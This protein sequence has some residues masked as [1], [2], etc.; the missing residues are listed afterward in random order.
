MLC[1]YKLPVLTQSNCSPSGY[2]GTKWKHWFLASPA[3][4]YKVISDFK[5]RKPAIATPLLVRQQLLSEMKSSNGTQGLTCRRTGFYGSSPSPCTTFSFYQ[6]IHQSANTSDNHPW[7]RNRVTQWR[8]RYGQASI[9]IK[10]IFKKKSRKERRSYGGPG[11]T[12]LGVDLNALILRKGK[13]WRQR[14]AYFCG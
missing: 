1:L 7:G 2:E 6:W 12:W 5:G 8:E 4:R 3:E 9:K 10:T 14:I 11:K 13:S